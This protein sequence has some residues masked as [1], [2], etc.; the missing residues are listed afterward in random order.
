MR[1]RV[2]A[3]GEGN[4]GGDG[5]IRALGYLEFLTQEVEPSRTTLVGARNG[6]NELI[7]LAMLWTV[8]H[9]WPVGAR[10]AFN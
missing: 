7:R 1:A 5:T 8:W 2:R 3:K 10:F 6:F 9:R 4:E